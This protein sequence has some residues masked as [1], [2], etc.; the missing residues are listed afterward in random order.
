M[1]PSVKRF[2]SWLKTW[3]AFH[4][5]GEFRDWSA[6]Q[7]NFFEEHYTPQNNRDKN[8]AREIVEYNRARL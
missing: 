7:I 5:L 8:L 4:L 1:R 6:E 3:V 2:I